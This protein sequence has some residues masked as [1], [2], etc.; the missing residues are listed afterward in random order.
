LKTKWVGTVAIV[1]FLFA[2]WLFSRNAGKELTGSPLSSVLGGWQVANNALYMRGEITV[3]NKDLPTSD[4]RTLDSISDYFFNRVGF[5]FSDFLY[6]HPGNFFIQYWKGPLKIYMLRRYKSN[7]VATWAEVSPLFMKYGTYLIKS[8]P[9]SYVRYFLMPNAGHY[10]L[11]SIE[12]LAFYNLGSDSVWQSAVD[13][14]RYKS[15]VIKSPAKNPQGHLLQYYPYIFL[16]INLVLLGGAGW[17]MIDKREATLGPNL[18]SLVVL[19]L[20]FWVSNFFFSVF[21]NII[22]LRYQFFPMII[23]AS[24]GVLLCEKLDSIKEG[25]VKGIIKPK[26][27]NQIL[28]KLET[29]I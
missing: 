14:F 15:Q 1:P 2:F 10:C 11:P 12:K 24:L 9:L 7:S 17:W 4:L 18:R 8:H 28:D 5:G 27:G 20:L 13:W 29:S 19:L 26:I 16:V 3:D 23:F 21:A 22:V 25:D 6:D